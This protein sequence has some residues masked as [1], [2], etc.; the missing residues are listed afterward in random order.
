MEHP[1]AMVPSKNAITVTNTASPVE[2]A[3]DKTLSMTLTGG[4][5]KFPPGY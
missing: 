3:A 5:P 1:V 4:L 2:L